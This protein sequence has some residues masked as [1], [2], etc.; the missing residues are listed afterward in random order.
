VVSIGV[1]ASSSL[2]TGA[3]AGVGALDFD[4]RLPM[5]ERAG[6]LNQGEELRGAFLPRS[7]KYAYSRI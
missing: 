3:G 7:A 6:N 1:L 2:M 5:V 4:L